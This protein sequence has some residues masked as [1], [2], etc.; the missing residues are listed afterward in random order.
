MSYV[1]DNLLP[2]VSITIYSVI[3]P[4]LF[5]SLLS[6]WNSSSS[7]VG[8]APDR[9]L[10]SYVFSIM[11]F[12]IFCIFLYYFLV[13]FINTV[14]YQH[15]ILSNFQFLRLLFALFLF[16][17]P[18]I[19]SDFSV[20][21]NL[22]GFSFYSISCNVSFTFSVTVALVLCLEVELVTR[23]ASPRGGWTQ[24]WLCCWRSSKC[25]VQ[26]FI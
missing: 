10:M 18:W 9:L 15:F 12:C 23:W 13:N 1:L 7:D 21:T 17:W 19:F 16:S 25:R 4:F 20:E 22:L 14:F 6:F 3:F 26:V 5:S 2:S 8:P 11:Y 24:S